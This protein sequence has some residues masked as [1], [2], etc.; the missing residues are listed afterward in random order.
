MNI[1]DELRN[2]KIIYIISLIFAIASILVILGVAFSEAQ[3]LNTSSINLIKGETNEEISYNSLITASKISHIEEREN[4]IILPSDSSIKIDQTGNKYYMNVTNGYSYLEI[5]RDS[6]NLNIGNNIVELQN[7]SGIYN[8]SGFTIFSGSTR[9]NG[10]EYNINDTIT[11]DNR[12]GDWVSVNF[13]RTNLNSN[14]QL[15]EIVQELDMLNILPISL[16]DITPPT[17]QLISP[18]ITATEMRSIEISGI[19]EQGA[20]VDIN[21]DKVSVDVS[22]KFN[23]EIDLVEGLNNIEITASDGW[24]ESIERINVTRITPVITEPEIINNTDCEIGETENQVFCLLN[25]YRVSNNLEPLQF[26]RA[27]GLTA[28]QYAFYEYIEEYE[29]IPKNDYIVIH[30]EE[31][32]TG[33]YIYTNLIT[34]H[35][36][37]INSSNTRDI[38]MG[39]YKNIAYII[40]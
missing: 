16:N 33:N 36:S 35:N 8:Q 34:T 29:S 37:V 21:D 15:R 9:L 7:V 30:S 18:N 4:T 17:I 14:P 39:V 12:L 26:D 38:S 6:M 23:H 19:T 10:A 5:G 25:N 28:R 2:P 20:T 27:M 32:L 40:L 24:N 13:D 22:G 11:F 1:K 31:K 3:R